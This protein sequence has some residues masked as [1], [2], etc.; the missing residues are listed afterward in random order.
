MLTTILLTMLQGGAAPADDDVAQLK[1]T[2]PAFS[3][4]ADATVLFWLGRA[5]RQVDSSW[6]DADRDFARRLLACHLMTEQGLGT[7]AEAEMFSA[8][9]GGFDSMKSG[10]L[11]LTRA[12]PNLAGATGSYGSTQY[13]RQFAVLAA[14]VRGGARVTDTGAFPVGFPGGY[15]WA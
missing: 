14:Q 9:A 1:A 6:P 2:F 8:G 11:T 10:S 5:A 3:A 13:G 12:A 15:L 7:G 4:V